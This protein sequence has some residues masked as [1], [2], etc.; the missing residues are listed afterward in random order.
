MHVLRNYIVSQ[1]FVDIHGLGH[2]PADYSSHETMNTIMGC[3]VVIKKS[4][5]ALKPPEWH[6]ILHK[7]YRENPAIALGRH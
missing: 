2:M 7:G 5:R 1:L 4:R 3:A 6:C